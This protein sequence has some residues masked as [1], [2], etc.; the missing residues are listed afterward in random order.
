MPP[1]ISTTSSSLLDRQQSR[2]RQVTVGARY[3]IQIQRLRARRPTAPRS[4]RF[5]IDNAGARSARRATGRPTDFDNLTSTGARAVQDHQPRRRPDHRRQCGCD[6]SGPR[7]SRSTI[8][9]RSAYSAPCWSRAVRPEAAPSTCRSA[10]AA[11]SA[12]SAGGLDLGRQERH[13]RGGRQRRPGSTTM[14]AQPSSA[15]TAR[16]SARR[17]RH[18]VRQLR[19]HH[20][21]RSTV[22][23]G[24]A[25][26]ATASISTPC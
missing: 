23:S 14:P 21:A 2:A 11:P 7:I 19:H 17:Q 8:T 6:P 1:P 20:R 18:A 15:A 10:T 22:I 12:T 4:G 26:M 9:A 5:S 16:A 25:A 13:T 24:R 3:A